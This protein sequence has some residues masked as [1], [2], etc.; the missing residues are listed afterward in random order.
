M[1]RHYIFGHEP[2]S[3]PLILVPYDQVQKLMDEISAFTGIKVAIPCYPFQMSFFNDGCPQ[4]QFLGVSNSREEISALTDGLSQIETPASY[5]VAPPGA[6][7]QQL[8]DFEAWQE[9]VDYGLNVGKKSKSRARLQKDSAMKI[10]HQGQLERA[11]RFL[12]LRQKASNVQ[13]VC[14]DEKSQYLVDDLIDSSKKSPFEFEEKIVFVCVDVEAWEVSHNIITEIG[15]ST[16]D[17]SDL[18]DIPPGNQGEEWIK[19]IRSRHI[20]INGTEDKGNFK[21]VSGAPDKFRFGQSEWYSKEDAANVVDD[22]FEHPFSKG[23]ECAAPISFV[24]GS[25]PNTSS[26]PTHLTKD[27]KDLDEAPTRNV[28][29]LGHSVSG[30][31]DYLRSLGSSIFGDGP[32][33]TDKEEVMV[34]KRRVIPT[35]RETL[36]TNTIYKAIHHVRDVKSLSGIC[37]EY[38]VDALFTHNAG[39]DARYTMEAFVKMIVKS[40]Q[41]GEV[42]TT[43]TDLQPG[44]KPNASAVREPV[45][46]D[47]IAQDFRSRSSIA[48]MSADEDDDDEPPY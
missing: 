32:S 45:S 48:Q 41:P 39:N 38:D 19:K 15:V 34:R 1:D 40:R 2:I 22:C 31:V 44:D 8:E 17:T 42:K 30:D 11:Q 46:V 7:I 6:S 10:Q 21:F 25:S 37:Q 18:I 33:G 13:V 28:I 3:K 29:L 36:D 9:K 4:P 20:R 27:Q 47:T 26:I 14:K 35:I 24:C 16:L 12:G 43:Q 23:F 5:G